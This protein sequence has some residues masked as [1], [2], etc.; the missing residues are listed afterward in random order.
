MLGSRNKEETTSVKQVVI[1]K[2]K[3]RTAKKIKTEYK[4]ERT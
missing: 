2:F 4:P 3:H 1:I